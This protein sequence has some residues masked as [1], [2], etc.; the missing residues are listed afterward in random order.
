MLRERVRSYQRANPDRVRESRRKSRANLTP[1]QASERNRRYQL[2]KYGMTIESWDAMFAAQDGRC[3]LCRSN[4]PGRHWTVDHDHTSGAVRGILCWHC[5]VGLGHF[6]D[7][8]AT[9]IAAAD[10]VMRGHGEGLRHDNE[11]TSS[12][13]G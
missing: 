9:L 4:E 5:N 7:D 12:R 6:R 11:A 13:I 1:A 3:A 10:Y 8:A 2:K